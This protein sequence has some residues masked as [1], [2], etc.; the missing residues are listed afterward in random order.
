MEQ[1]D[2]SLEE[3]QA[4]GNRIGEEPEFVGSEDPS[5][6]TIVVKSKKRKTTKKRKTQKKKK[7]SLKRRKVR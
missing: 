7:L 1:S 3:K 2:I 4:Y 6:K 5:Q